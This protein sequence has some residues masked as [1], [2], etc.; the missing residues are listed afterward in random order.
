MIMRKTIAILLALMTII[1]I[2]SSC[3]N[4]A[5]Q[6]SNIHS[7]DIEPERVIVQEFG[8]ISPSMSSQI[9]DVNNLEAVTEISS[10]I[11]KCEIKSLDNVIYTDT[12]EFNFEYSV[13]VVEIMLDVS[14]TLAVG[15]II[16]VTS[17]EGIMK[18]SEAAKMIKDSP[19]AKKF[20]ILQGKY[21]DN[22]YI[23]SSTWDAI[24]IEVGKTYIMFIT[25]RYYADEGVYAESGRSFLFEV[26]EQSVYSSRAMTR[27][28]KTTND[29]VSEILAQIEVRTGRADEVGVDQYMIELGEK[30]KNSNDK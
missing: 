18:A 8:Y 19:R 1:S 5:D 21:N 27:N 7:V 11:I 22:D 17:S 2:L 10:H 6:E 4:S 30:Q 14:G 24:P 13:E 25:D 9:A 29:I 15:D 20:G 23:T 26:E 3:G 12:D 16:P 28:K